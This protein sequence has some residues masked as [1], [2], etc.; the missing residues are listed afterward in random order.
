MLF[1]QKPVQ[2]FKNNNWAL[3]F[4]NC[5]NILIVLLIIYVYSKYY[6][7]KQVEVENWVKSR[8]K[9][10]AA[11]RKAEVP[12]FSCTICN[13]YDSE[14]CR[15]SDCGPSFIACKDCMLKEH[16]HRPLHSIEN[17]KVSYDSHTCDNWNFVKK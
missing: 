9:L 7:G 15:C 2:F 3:Y 17:W 11:A 12:T 1:R 10:H 13:R 16:E 14:I 4:G 5:L 6:C 8:I